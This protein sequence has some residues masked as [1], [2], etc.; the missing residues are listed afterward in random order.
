M[1]LHS[2]WD[3]ACVLESGILDI[4]VS[5]LV[6]GIMSINMQ[7]IYQSVT[8]IYRIIHFS[9]VLFPLQY[10]IA[11]GFLQTETCNVKNLH[12]YSLVVLY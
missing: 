9:V 5:D 4:T 11:K 3:Y 10:I 12:V 1:E 8:P 2:R 7:N 6:S